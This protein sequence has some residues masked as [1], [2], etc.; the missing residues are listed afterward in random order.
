[1]RFSPDGSRLAVG[2][3]GDVAVGVSS[4]TLHD[5]ET[6]EPVQR[7]RH[8]AEAVT[9]VAFS[10]QGSHLGV[11]TCRPG[12]LVVWDWRSNQRVF[13][14]QTSDC[15]SAVAFSP[16]EPLVV[17]TGYDLLPTAWDVETGEER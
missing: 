14:E 17:A 7:L 1:L 8:F 11:A 5:T 2:G 10:S 3:A 6:V 16:A 15:L 4:V 9:D 12:R 13:L